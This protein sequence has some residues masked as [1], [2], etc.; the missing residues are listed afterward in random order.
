MNSLK[1]LNG[2]KYIVLAALAISLGASLSSAQE[3][4]GNFNLPFP[5]R[6]GGIALAPGEYTF[7]CG[8]MTVGGV[9]MITVRR[10]TRTLGMIQ[11]YMAAPEKQFSKSSASHLTA[12]RTAAGYSITALKL[13]ENGIELLFLVPKGKVLMA[14]QTARPARNVPVLLAGK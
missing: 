10:G 12:M 14:S 8:A 11:T 7:T 5:A 9:P 4:H 13:R 3:A 1:R 6:W 2:M